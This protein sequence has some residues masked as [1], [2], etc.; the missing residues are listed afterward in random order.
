LPLALLAWLEAGTSFFSCMMWCL[1]QSIGETIAKLIFR[2]V[3]DCLWRMIAEALADAFGC[4]PGDASVSLQGGATTTM[5][6]LQVGDRVLTGD[7][8][9]RDVYFF[10]HQEPH[11][12]TRFV[13]VT[14]QSKETLEATVDHYVPVSRACDGVTENMYASEVQ[15][16]MCLFSS[17]H[18]LQRVTKVAAVAKYGIFN[19]FTLSGDIVVNGVVASSHSSWFLDVLAAKA[20]LT[21]LVPSVYQ[22]ILAPARVLYGAVG[23][24]VARKELEQYKGEMT[25][26]AD[27][28]LVV[29]PYMDLT[30]RA[31]A[32]LTG[33]SS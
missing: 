23:P 33:Y 21:W 14:L 24:A 2:L 12:K 32:I 4:F 6:E 8:S 28:A 18:G 22:L 29:K 17:R 9:Y 13:A 20:S 10:A 15:Q 31:F 25:R 26:A 16:G 11:V 5:S 3:K 19:P 27:Q 30:W 7:G 1:L